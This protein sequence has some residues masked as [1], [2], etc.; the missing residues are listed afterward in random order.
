MCEIKRI[1][2]ETLFEVIKEVLSQGDKVHITVTGMSM[3]PFLREG[4]DGVELIHGS[5]VDINRGDIVIIQRET[6]EYVMHRVLNK[7]LDHFYIIGDAQQ[8]IEGPLRPDQL[9]AIVTAVWRGD[10]RIDCANFWWKILSRLWLR[11]IPFRY[12]I[13]GS[14]RRFRRILQ[15]IKVRMNVSEKKY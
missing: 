12:L 11:L 9:I 1:K 14:Y 6:G 15:M 2:S 3:Y 10:K 4:I 5:Y 13:L 8:W 7:H